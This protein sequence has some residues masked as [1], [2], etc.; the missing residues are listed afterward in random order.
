[1]SKAPRPKINPELEKFLPRANDDLKAGLREKLER[2]SVLEPILV[3]EDGD[4]ADGHT[5]LELYAEAGIK[6]FPVEVVYGPK[7]LEEKKAWMRDHQLHR[8]N[9]SPNEWNYLWG[10][11]FN[12]EKKPEGNP[13]LVQNGPVG[14]SI[15]KQGATAAR[16]GEESGSSAST[17][18]RAGDFAAA[19]ELQPASVRPSL[20]AGIVPRD[21]VIA[22]QG[23]PLICPACVRKGIRTICP[24]CKTIQAAIRRN[25][26]GT[27]GKG[28][29]P[30]SSATA[31]LRKALLNSPGKN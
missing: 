6:K 24:D 3:F 11:K 8:R 14:K 10:M 9:L 4:V 17:I 29:R 23:K 2:D 18:K 5:R 30:P 15:E 20:I 16:L 22:A 1:M 7:T 25:A 31:K 27:K 13:Q 12:E 19:V 21:L 28:E 26:A